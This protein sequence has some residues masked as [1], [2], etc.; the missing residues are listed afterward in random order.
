VYGK[1]DARLR[2]L[3]EGLRSFGEKKDENGNGKGKGKRAKAPRKPEDK[4]G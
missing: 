1:V 3:A 4:Q 2:E